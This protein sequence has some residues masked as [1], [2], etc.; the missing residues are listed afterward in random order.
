MDWIRLWG[1]EEIDLN[2]KSDFKEWYIN[3]FSGAKQ[4]RVPTSGLK[5]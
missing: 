1:K 3:T 2:E 5:N 4:V